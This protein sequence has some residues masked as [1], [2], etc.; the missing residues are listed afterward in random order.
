M[1]KVILFLCLILGNI[2]VFAFVDEIYVY[3]ES[4]VLFQIK[5]GNSKSKEKQILNTYIKLFNNFIREIDSNQT[6]FIQFD[7][8]DYNCDFSFYTLSYGI[9]SDF[10][11]YGKIPFENSER[12]SEKFDKKGIVIYFSNNFLKLK[13]ILQLIEYGF[14]K[15]K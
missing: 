9:F 14:K 12:I 6:V 11:L 1:K 13:P 15:Q 4:N 5:S 3:E 10:A 2:S 8:Q 7:Q